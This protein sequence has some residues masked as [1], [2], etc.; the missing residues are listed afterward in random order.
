MRVISAVIIDL[1]DRLTIV[2]HQSFQ[3]HTRPQL[4]GNVSQPRDIAP[5]NVNELRTNRP[6]MELR[7]GTC[8]LLG[9]RFLNRAVLH[10]DWSGAVT[11]RLMALTGAGDDDGIS[12]L[13]L[14]S[15]QTRRSIA[16]FS[17]TTAALLTLALLSTADLRAGTRLWRFD[18]SFFRGRPIRSRLSHTH[19]DISAGVK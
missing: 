3:R 12:R 8:P 4:Y 7:R 19:D 1:R 14:L 10:V 18:Y 9:R 5:T 6:L 16:C 13:R 17:L 2:E 11:A 15:W